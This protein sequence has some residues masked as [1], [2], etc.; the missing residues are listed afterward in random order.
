VYHN[1]SGQDGSS[2]GVLNRRPQFG[3][4]PARGPFSAA[5][6][7]WS[8]PLFPV[9]AGPFCGRDSSLRPPLL[10]M[11]RPVRRSLFLQFRRSE[12]R[13]SPV[14]AVTAGFRCSAA[15]ATL[16]DIRPHLSRRP[17]KSSPAHA[18]ADEVFLLDRSC[19]KHPLTGFP[20]TLRKHSASRCRMGG[21]SIPYGGQAPAHDYKRQ[22]DWSRAFHLPIPRS[23][24]CELILPGTQGR[25][26]ENH[27]PAFQVR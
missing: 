5:S 26:V 2:C 20:V 19:A 14:G 18:V 16:S 22:Q 3:P 17:T 9:A 12:G 21:M 27:A 10:F 13:T 15:R 24:G 1:Q 8:D 6:V 4:F 11:A 23:F 7:P 25:S